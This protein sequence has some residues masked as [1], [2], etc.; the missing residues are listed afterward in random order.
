MNIV[1]EAQ[2]DGFVAISHSNSNGVNYR[3]PQTPRINGYTNG[4]SVSPCADAENVPTRG[5]ERISV[6]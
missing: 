5:G 2:V 6:K 3:S 4:D 1:T